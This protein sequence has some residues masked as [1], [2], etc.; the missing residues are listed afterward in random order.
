MRHTL[1]AARPRIIRPASTFALL[2]AISCAV[3]ACA[4]SPPQTESRPELAQAAAPL[5]LAPRIC[6]PDRALLNQHPAPDC[7]FRPT[8][9]KT[10]DPDEWARL[11]IEYERQCYRNAEKTARD[12]LLRLQAAVRCDT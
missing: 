2:A 6:Q 7:A 10:V 3:S 9:P 12:R 1:H 4:P 11:K 8:D 5:P